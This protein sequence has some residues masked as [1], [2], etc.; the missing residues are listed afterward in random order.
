MKLVLVHNL[1]P[2]MTVGKDV[3]DSNN[4]L[5]T[6]AGAKLTDK[7]ISSLLLHS[8]LS[9]YVLEEQKN[10]QE[11]LQQ[12]IPQAHDRLREFEKEIK[13]T[14]STLK[15]QINDVVTK[16]SP[17]R[18][19]ELLSHTAALFTDDMTTI[20]LFDMLHHMR[21][22]DDSTFIHS[23]NVALICNV[24]G[25]WMNLDKTELDVL[26][27]CGLLH[28]IGKLC[29]PDSI[30]KKPGKLSKEEYDVIKRH[31][32][33]GYELLKSHKELDPRVAQAALMHHERCDGTGYPTG[34]YRR[35]IPDYALI[36]AIADV[37]DAMTSKR[38]YRDALSPFKVIHILEQEGI[39]K[40][41]PHYILTFLEQIINSFVN[42]DVMLSSGQKAHIIFI[43]KEQLS[44]P[45]VKT[46]N[47]IIDLSKDRS[48]EIEAI[49]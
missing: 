25:K 3:Y 11:P 15:N 37:Y 7:I 32:F 45:V 22:Y 1:K 48:L 13:R 49:I 39:Q 34:C 19:D 29:I 10:S 47:R 12:K 40:Y 24:F 36:V 21:S 41:D 6:P 8:I 5:L 18:P 23:V 38:V 17:F 20:R 31:P 33:K 35:S 9:I 43:N 27:L 28:D 44:R 2:G 4:L 26:T 42:T 16:N 30:V 46:G 14:T